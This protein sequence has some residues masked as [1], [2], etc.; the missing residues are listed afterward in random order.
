M[1]IL[2]GTEEGTGK[3]AKLS[4]VLL[5]TSIPNQIP[6]LDLI[7]PSKKFPKTW[8]KREPRGDRGTDV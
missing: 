1:L 7:I 2:I 4:L 5:R 3:V 6:K 8:V